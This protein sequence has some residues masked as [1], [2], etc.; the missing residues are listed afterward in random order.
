MWIAPPVSGL[1]VFNAG[2]ST[3]DYSSCRLSLCLY[4]SGLLASNAAGPSHSTSRGSVESGQLCLRSSHFIGCLFGVSAMSPRN[5]DS[6]LEARLGI[7]KEGV[8]FVCA[9]II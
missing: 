4:S 1:S 2:I 9:T 7:R 8:L 6:Q 3:G 5:M